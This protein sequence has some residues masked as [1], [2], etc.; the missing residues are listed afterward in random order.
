MTRDMVAAVLS[1]A[2]SLALSPVFSPSWLRPVGSAKSMARPSRNRPRESS[3]LLMYS[4]AVRRFERSVM[5]NANAWEVVVQ[6]GIKT[7]RREENETKKVL[8]RFRRLKKQD[9]VHQQE[10]AVAVWL[11]NARWWC[12]VNVNVPCLEFP[13]FPFFLNFLFLQEIFLFRLPSVVPRR[14]FHPCIITAS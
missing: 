2:L 3:W 14:S 9:A 6:K 10:L 7:D 12:V 4:E 1:L 13:L 8:K 5:A 11:V